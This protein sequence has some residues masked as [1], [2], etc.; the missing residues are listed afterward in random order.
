M[1]GSCTHGAGH[2]K[3]LAV[4]KVQAKTVLPKE[5]SHSSAKPLHVILPPK[6]I[7]NSYIKRSHAKWRDGP[8]VEFQIKDEILNQGEVVLPLQAVG[9]WVKVLSVKKVKIGWVHYQTLGKIES[10]TKQFNLDLNML[11]KVF[12]VHQINQAFSYPESAPLGVH[13]EKGMIFS[14]LLAK[15]DK[16]LVYIESTNSVMWLKKG[17]AQ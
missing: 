5:F 13:I 7:E 9:V 17:D 12:A 3:S 2:E 15:Q 16:V 1:L 4:V 14:R 8:G 6:L 11:P 10:N